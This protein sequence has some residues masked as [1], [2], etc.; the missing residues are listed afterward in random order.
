MITLGTYAPTPKIICLGANK[1]AEYGVKCRK[2]FTITNKIDIYRESRV[3]II[4]EDDPF[5][6]A[7]MSSTIKFMLLVKIASLHTQIKMTIYP[8]ANAV[9]TR[10]EIIFVID[11]GIITQKEYDHDNKVIACIA[12]ELSDAFDIEKKRQFEHI[13]CNLKNAKDYDMHI[14]FD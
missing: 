3:E 2:C 1:C 7:I 11:G 14:R 13:T 5:V 8:M 12:Y 10:T 9:L 6:M 4:N